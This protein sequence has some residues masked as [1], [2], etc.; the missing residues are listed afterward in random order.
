MCAFHL[1]ERERTTEGIERYSNLL[2]QNGLLELIRGIAN[3]QPDTIT[4]SKYRQFS[5]VLPEDKQLKK[6]T[7]INIP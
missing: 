1:F 4:L 3:T 5:Q 2:D 7:G 6:K